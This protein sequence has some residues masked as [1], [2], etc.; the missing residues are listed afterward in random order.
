MSTTSINEKT[1]KSDAVA[2]KGRIISSCVAITWNII[3]LVVFAFCKGYIA[4]YQLEHNIGIDQWVKYPFLSN[5]Y[6]TWLIIF[7]AAMVL[8][9]A[10]H[11]VAII[12]DKYVVRE[13]ILIGTKLLATFA[14]VTLLTIFPFDFSGVPDSLFVDV[15]PIIIRLLISFIIGVLGIATI[16]NIIKFVASIATKTPSY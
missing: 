3:L 11:I 6:N 13:S 14:V 16:V 15:S 9:I 1:P 12:I 5:S 4:Y 10:G 2:R 7:I 8:T